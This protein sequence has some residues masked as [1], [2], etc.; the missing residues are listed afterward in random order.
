MSTNRERMAAR[1]EVLCDHLNP[2]DSV[3][4]VAIKTDEYVFLSGQC[5]LDDKGDVLA[6]GDCAEQTRLTIERFKE[7]LE[8]A[9]GDLSNIVK[10]TV[11]LTNRQNFQK[12]N[13]VWREYFG[14]H[15]PTR[16]TIEVGLMHPDLLVEVEA[17]AF[18]P[19]DEG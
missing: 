2:I 3:L 5:A 16:S 8:A 13:G 6:V 9:G 4:S 11:F 14:D 10:A 17:I 12:M 1:T 19:R 15:P 18:I 7:T